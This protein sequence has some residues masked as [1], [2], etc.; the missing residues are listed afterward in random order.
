MHP[1]GESHELPPRPRPAN[2]IV[3]RETI[4]TGRARRKDG[5]LRG[6]QRAFQCPWLEYTH[7]SNMVCVLETTSP[8]ISASPMRQES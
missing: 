5:F 1:A 2:W 3:A 6:Y 4:G 8:Y 7:L